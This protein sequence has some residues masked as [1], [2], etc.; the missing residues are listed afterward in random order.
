MISSYIS[1]DTTDNEDA[2]L[3]KR[4]AAYVYVHRA[5]Y[6]ATKHGLLGL[7]K[8]A[9]LEVAT[10]GVTVNAICPGVIRGDFATR[11]LSHRAETQ[12][13]TLAEEE[14]SSNPMQRL[15]EPEEISDLAVYL[16]SD[17]AQGITGQAINVNGGSI[18]D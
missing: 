10:T 5:A 13:T 7:T 3:S 2:I 9:A 12:G 15:L 14:K 16:A 6:S 1:S 8:T 4:W 18:M 11:L 17:A